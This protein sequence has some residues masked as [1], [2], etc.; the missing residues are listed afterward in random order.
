MRSMGPLAT[1]GKV[2]AHGVRP[3]AATKTTARHDVNTPREETAMR[4]TVFVMMVLALAVCM[5]GCPRSGQEDVS[6][7]E[8]PVKA[9]HAAVAEDEKP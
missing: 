3:I 1:R 4:K 7:D 9:K 6:L 5:A 2:G 8:G